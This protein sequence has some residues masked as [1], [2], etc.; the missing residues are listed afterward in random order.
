VIAD[1]CEHRPLPR[2]DG[3]DGSLEEVGLALLDEAA[4]AL[5]TSREKLA[6]D[7]LEHK[8]PPSGGCRSCSRGMS[9]SA[10]GESSRVALLGFAGVLLD[11]DIS[12]G[13]TASR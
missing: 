6:S 1:P 7:I 9:R 2:A 4:C 13:Y 8:S 10:R 3:L 11:N 12:N 5:G